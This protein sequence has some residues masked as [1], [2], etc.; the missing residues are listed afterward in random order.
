M[1]PGNE[2]DRL[3]ELDDTVIEV[4]RLKLRTIHSPGSY[5]GFDELEA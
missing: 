2:R 3:L 1:S 5:A 4:G